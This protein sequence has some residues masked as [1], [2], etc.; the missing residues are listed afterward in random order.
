MARRSARNVSTQVP[1]GAALKLAA[2]VP[3]LGLRPST[4]L[5]ITKQLASERIDSWRRI[6]RRT[7][8]VVL[9]FDIFM[10]QLRKTKPGFATFYTNH[11]A[12]AMHRYWAAAFPGDYE[13]SEYDPAWIARFS[14]E[15][16]FAMS[17]FDAFFERMSGFVDAH[18]DYELWVT[19]SMGQA[20]TRAVRLE[21]QLYLT[22]LAPF[23]ATLGFPAEQW[24][25]RPAMEPQVA[26]QVDERAADRFRSAVKDVLVDGAP[27]EVD[28][29]ERGFFCISLGQPNLAGRVEEAVIAG[30]GVPFN[31]LGM[32]HV[33]IEDQTNSNA[34]HVPGGILLI[35][36]A[37]MA[38]R[39][40]GRPVISTLD[41]APAILRNYGITAPSYM[42]AG[43]IAA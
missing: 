24:E 34:Y 40:A 16:D 33:P 11:A 35:Y 39:S 23:M 30:R 29:R 8:Q 2:A 18:P 5:S 12:S 17:W 42:A 1:L 36:G 15:I 28:E 41:I 19:T 31:Q 21:T 38:A 32:E 9:A 14:G 22:D 26:V 43:Q 20:A 13:G 25:R 10:K 7:F 3:S 4:L 6:R 37:G 27:I